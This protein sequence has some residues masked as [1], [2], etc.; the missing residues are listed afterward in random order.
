MSWVD[1]SYRRFQV[2]TTSR[3]TDVSRRTRL[4]CPD[5]VEHRPMSW[6]H[7]SYCHFQVTTTSRDTDVSRHTRL[8]WTS[9][10][11]FVTQ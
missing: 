7:A 6:V 1:A 2:T 3:D 5:D 8:L 10:Y 11:V 9:I 4:L